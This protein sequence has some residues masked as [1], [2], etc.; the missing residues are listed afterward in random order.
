MR[1]CSKLV[2]V[3]LVHSRVLEA[4]PF[5]GKRLLRQSHQHQQVE[6]KQTV[7]LACTAGI[8]VHNGECD[9]TLAMRHASDLQQHRMLT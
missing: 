9:N 2:V 7:G 4:E 5:V 6:S 1:C 3:L 8:A